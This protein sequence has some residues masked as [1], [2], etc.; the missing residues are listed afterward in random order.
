MLRKKI[1]VKALEG[2]PFFISEDEVIGSGS[3]GR[4]VK[5]YNKEEPSS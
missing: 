1:K 5:A 4:V 2:T 3:F